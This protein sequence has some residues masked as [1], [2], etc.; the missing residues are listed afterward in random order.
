MVIMQPSPSALTIETYFD[1]DDDGVID[2][3]LESNKPKVAI[4]MAMPVRLTDNNMCKASTSSDPTKVSPAYCY[5][6]FDIVDADGEVDLPDTLPTGPILG[7][8]DLCTESMAWATPGGS[9]INICKTEDGRY[10][11]GRVGAS[12]ARMTLQ[13]YTK[14]DGTPG[15]WFIMAY[16]ESKALGEYTIIAGRRHQRSNRNRQ[17]YLVSH[18]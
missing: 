1:Q 16:E 11:N 15:A 18:L 12:R 6:D 14:A 17:E 3:D 5:V 2:E 10:L 9:T 8:S 7:S 13:P 4:P